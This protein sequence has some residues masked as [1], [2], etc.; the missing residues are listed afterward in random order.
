MRVLDIKASK[1]GDWVSFPMV[2][3][4]LMVAKATGDDPVFV[5]QR[6]RAGDR[7]ERL[8]K[9]AVEAGSTGGWGD[10]ITPDIIA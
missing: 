1:H 4:C 6:M 10:Q 9:T 2:A 7:I 8:V 3:R 5:A